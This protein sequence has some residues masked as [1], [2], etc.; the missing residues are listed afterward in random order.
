MELAVCLQCFVKKKIDFVENA[1]RN[2]NTRF[3]NPLKMYAYNPNKL[4][5]KINNIYW[6]T[7]L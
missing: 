2:I 6:E 3:R 1:F 4:L 5:L 7:E